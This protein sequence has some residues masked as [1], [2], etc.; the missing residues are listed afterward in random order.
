[1]L[2]FAVFYFL[3]IALDGSGGE[4]DFLGCCQQKLLNLMAADTGSDC[5]LYVVKP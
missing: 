2:A 3:L 1:M 5:P 4:R